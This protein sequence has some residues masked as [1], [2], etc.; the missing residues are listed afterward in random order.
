MS[1]LINKYII[2]KSG[3]KGSFGVLTSLLNLLLMPGQ[4][5]AFS[6]DTGHMYH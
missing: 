5:S 4:I 1:K 3:V 6:Q 2:E